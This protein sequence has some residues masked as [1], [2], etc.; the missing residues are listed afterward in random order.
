MTLSNTATDLDT[1]PG[2]RTGEASSV[3]VVVAFKQRYPCTAVTN[4]DKSKPKR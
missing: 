3:V 4:P 1:N 2:Y